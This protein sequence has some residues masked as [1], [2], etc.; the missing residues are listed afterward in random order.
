[1]IDEGSLVASLDAGEQNIPPAQFIF[2]PKTDIATDRIAFGGR[3]AK[4]I[5]EGAQKCVDHLHRNV[6]HKAPAP[7]DLSVLGGL[8]ANAHAVRQADGGSKV[9]FERRTVPV[10]D[11][12]FHEA[13]RKSDQNRAGLAG[14]HL[15]AGG[16]QERVGVAANLEAEVPGRC[17]SALHARQFITKFIDGFS[18]VVV[19]A[20]GLF[21][22]PNPAEIVISVAIPEPAPHLEQRVVHHRP[23]EE[24]ADGQS[25]ECETA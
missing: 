18:D 6:T 2:G 8:A 19:P 13:V 11:G 5:P 20:L 24:V 4:V 10:E 14:A 16:D 25:F 9:R 7:K 15:V 23:S 12:G 21:G 1:M 3:G 17:I 22:H